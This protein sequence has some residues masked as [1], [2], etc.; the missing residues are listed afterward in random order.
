MDR[1]YNVL[2]LGTRN[3]GRSILG[4]AALN[5]AGKGRFKAYSAGSLP[6]G[7]LHP[8]TYQ[9]LANTGLPADGLRSKSW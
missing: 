6:S 9:V 3:C 8:A 4:E 2:F 5:R 7:E 1:P